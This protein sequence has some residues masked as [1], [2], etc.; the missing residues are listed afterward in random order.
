MVYKVCAITASSVI[1]KFVLRPGASGLNLQL[2]E[3]IGL[4]RVTNPGKTGSNHLLPP[5]GKTIH[6]SPA[7][8]DGMSFKP[9]ANPGQ[10]SWPGFFC[11]WAASPI[12]FFAQ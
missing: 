2:S 3:S 4:Y 12:P 9:A 8:P 1:N 11:F 6:L 7:K 10:S 5:H